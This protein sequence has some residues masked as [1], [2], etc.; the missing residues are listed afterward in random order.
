MGLL[1]FTDVET[2]DMRSKAMEKAPAEAE[3]QPRI[4]ALAYILCDEAS[5]TV[6]GNYSAMVRPDGWT[7]GAE[8]YAVN[9]LD[10]D[11][12]LRRGLPIYGVIAAV[13]DV[14]ALGESEPLTLVAHGLQF[15]HKTIRGEL[16]RADFPKFYETTKR[17]C[18]MTSSVKQ[19]GLFQDGTRR[20]KWPSLP[21]TY[22]H[23]FGKPVTGHHSAFT[24]TF[25][26]KAIYFEKLKRG[27]D[28]TAKQ[29]DGYAVAERDAPKTESAEAAATSPAPEADRGGPDRRESAPEPESPPP[30]GSPSASL[31]PSDEDL[32]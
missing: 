32:I 4:A 29:P 10:M 13:A 2:N 31:P 3:G 12:L 27:E 11:T 28:M 20:P 17:F 6:I 9:G 21:E 24:D 18:T 15:D 16:R 30:P 8:A 1:L 19:V 25:A 22:Q 23:Y 7:M 5:G 26:C 14:L